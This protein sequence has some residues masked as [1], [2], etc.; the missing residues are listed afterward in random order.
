MEP[1]RPKGVAWNE[2]YRVNIALLDQQHHDLVTYLENLKGDLSAGREIVVENVLSRLV[3]YTIH[4]F[5]DEEDLLER[6]AFP[7]LAAHRIEHNAL[8]EKI[9]LFQEE[10]MAGKEGVL[11]SIVLYMED[12]LNDHMLKSDK[13]YSEFLNARGVI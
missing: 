8:T 6:H 11:F 4:H 5:A 1:S 13:E 7:G 3:Q 10:H 12:W 9:G 2:T